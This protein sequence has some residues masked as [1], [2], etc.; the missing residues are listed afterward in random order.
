TAT[1]SCF[2]PGTLVQTS[3]GLRKIEEI[4]S[5][6]YIINKYGKLARVIEPTVRQWC[7]DLINVKI[8][9]TFNEILV[10]P[11]HEFLY[12]EYAGESEWRR[13][14]SFKKTDSVAISVESRPDLWSIPYSFTFNSPID[15]YNRTING[16]FNEVDTLRTIGFFIAEGN[17]GNSGS[18]DEDR[19]TYIQFSTH[20][21][22][23]KLA[24][25]RIKLWA[26]RIGCTSISET[27]NKNKP[28]S[29]YLIIHSAA[30]ANWFMDLFG[31]RTNAANKKI[32]EVLKNLHPDLLRYLILG[33]YEG[34]GHSKFARHLHKKTGFYRTKRLIACTISKQLADDICSIFRRVDAHYNVNFV[35]SQARPDGIVRKDGYYI[36]CTGKDAEYALKWM[37]GL[38]S[39][40]NTSGYFS[41]RVFKI[42][43]QYYEG[44]V[45]CLK[46]EGDPSFSLSGGIIVHNC[47]IGMVKRHM[48]DN[49]DVKSAQQYFERLKAIFKP[50]NFYVELG[51]HDTSHNW[52]EGIFLT[53]STG[54]KLKFHG[55][56]NL[57]TE[58]GEITAAQLAKDWASGYEHKVLKAVKNRTQW[59][60][61]PELELVNVQKIEDYLPNDPCE[62]APDGDYDAGLNKVIKIFAKK[63]NVPIIIGDDSHYPTPD[64]KVV[65]DV[66]L[67]QSGPWRFYKSYHRQTNQ[68]I[69]DHFQRTLNT[70][71][72][73]FKTWVQ[74]SHEWAQKFKDFKFESSPSLPTKFYE[75]EY[76]KRPW[77]KEGDKNNS[78]RYIMELIKKHGRMDWKNKSYTDRLEQEIRL[79]HENG[80]I[81]LLPYFMTAEEVCD[82]FRS[83]KLLT[84]V[85]RGSAGGSLLAY[86][87][88]ITHVDPLRYNLSIER[89]L[90]LDRIQTGNLP[91]IDQDLPRQERDLL[92]DQESGWLK[93]RFGDH[94]SP[95]SVDSTLRVKNAIKDVSRAKRKHVPDDIEKL[96][97]L[98]S[99][100]P[101]GV[102]DIDFLLG[103]DNDAD[104]Q[105]PGAIEYDPALK[106]YI[107]KYPDDWETV[108]KAVSLNRQKSRHPSAFVVADK[109]IHEFIPLTTVGGVRCTAYTA[110]AVEA[111]G[112]I[113]ND[114]LGLN[115]LSDI[116]SCIKLIQERNKLN[117]PDEIIID[118]KKV[119]GFEV[120]PFNG[121]LYDIWD[122]PSDQAVFADIALGRTESVF[123]Y[124]PPG[125]VKWLT[126]FSDKKPDGN[127]GIDSIDAM[128]AL[129]AL[130]RPGPLYK[131]VTN[132][133]T[134]EK[135]NMLVEYA[136]RIRGLEPSSDVPQILNELVKDTNGVLTF[137]ESCQTIY[138][139]LTDCPG[140]EAENFRRDISKKN[141]QKLEKLY[142][143]FME[144]ASAKIGQANAKEVWDSLITFSGY[145]FCKAH[146]Y[147]YAITGYACAFLKHYFNLEWW[148][149]VLKNA[150]KKEVNEKFWMYVGHLID[151]PDINLSGPE[152]EIQNERIR[153]P[154]SLLTGVGEIAHAQLTQWGPYKDIYDLCLKSERHKI[155]NGTVNEIVKLFKDK[156]NKVKSPT[157]GR[158]VASDIEI[159][160]KSIEKAHSAINRGVVYKLIISGAL[161]SLFP[162]NMHLGEQLATYEE[163]LANAINE[164]NAEW[165]KQSGDLKPYKPVKP[166]PVDPAKW[167]IGPFK[168]YQMR[169]Q[170]LSAYGYDLRQYYNLIDDMGIERNA[171]GYYLP[172]NDYYG[173]QKWID[174]IDGKE[175]IAKNND[176][177]DVGV[178]AVIAY[179]E[180]VE[181]GKFVKEGVTQEKC[182]IIIDV[183]SAKFEFMKWSNHKTNKVPD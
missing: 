162:P 160:I 88:R 125:V 75:I 173:K 4:K 105:V 71:E 93:K 104:G 60:D 166:E 171:D 87:L 158:M 56:K 156:N 6:D 112:G 172:W 51:T 43:K 38:T 10:T 13:I 41:N 59:N 123:Q 180:K 151:L 107:S 47:M 140:T 143:H 149:S 130:D 25:D 42:E 23:D 15:R 85:G 77:Y 52:V 62:W 8:T 114:Y 144:K 169:K 83:K 175:L 127:Y 122:L 136:R 138:Q 109:P 181:L 37:N 31:G 1:S 176:S 167:D 164:V 154:L 168:R 145:G 110:K 79:F 98:I 135:H 69:F 73:E 46:I 97:K 147:E 137:Q 35:K 100:C 64:Y 178:F 17:F 50:G 29:C 129:T 22:K 120:I 96:T 111:V 92:V 61:G 139:Y 81:D 65:Q 28:N 124:S 44:E 54:E 157:T 49:N 72:D 9:G 179:I 12:T 102:R 90:T 80:T 26:E 146:A 94:Y 33:Y 117:L 34:D 66:R 119:P 152:F 89:F 82:F 103:Y 39:H 148:T 177:Y 132:P 113:K 91:D 32:P 45:R 78:L 27:I 18:G 134:G 128:A 7:G 19:P 116:S 24:R 108:K 106:E 53:T 165:H 70:T 131:L 40:L 84:G 115:T 3:T 86:L 55:K 95:I 150:D 63:Y 99:D 183:E 16:D 101:V 163:A 170:I 20:T 68:E 182:K 133:E 74:N 141:K 5:G 67:A 153:A 11:D 159:K 142:V 126:H 121:R 155:D 2:V 76:K 58:N 118:G 21:I 36:I 174:I 48:F 161:D 57:L 14:E 30:I